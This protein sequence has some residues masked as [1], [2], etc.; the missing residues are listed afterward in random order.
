MIKIGSIATKTLDKEFPE[1]WTSLAR[2][3]GAEVQVSKSKHM[4]DLDFEN[5]ESITI[6]EDGEI[7]LSSGISPEIIYQII[8]E[9]SEK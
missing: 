9:L 2:I 8:I 4:I 5:G 3:I 7:V 6:D 1:R